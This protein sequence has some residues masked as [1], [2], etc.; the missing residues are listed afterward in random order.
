MALFSGKT[1]IVTGAGRGIGREHALQFA[2]EGA[3]VVV[4]DLGGGNDGSGHD[5]SAAQLVVDEI[6]AA[7]GTAVANTDSVASWEG[8]QRIVATAIDAYGGLDILVN[9]AGILRDRMIVNLTEDDIELVFGVHLHGTIGVTHHAARFWRDEAKAGRL[10][11]RRVVNT[12]S[13]SG[14]FGSAGQANYAA[15]KMGIAAFTI[16]CARELERYGVRA[17]A[18]APGA[19]TRLT[20]ATPGMGEIIEPPADE[21]VFDVWH[22]ANTTPI[23]LLLAA[24]DC[25]FN[26][27]VFETYGGTVALYQGWTRQRTAARDGRWTVDDLRKELAD[28]PVGPPPMPQL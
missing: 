20:L 1:V 11:P 21:D 25:A 27:Q 17:N 9:N 6:L 7:G 2:A 10:A 16:V 13:G 26:G 5:V 15:A 18:I 19:R 3:R 8:A 22:P 12:S 23:V 24:E 14:L 28:W 4:N